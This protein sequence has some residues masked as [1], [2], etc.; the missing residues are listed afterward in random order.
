[1]NYDVIINGLDVH[2][3]YSDESINN[4]F[5][6]LLRKLYLLQKEKGRRILVMLAAP[7]GAG[8]ST[9]LSFLKYLSESTEGVSPI[10]TIGMDGFHRYQDYLLSHTTLRDGKAIQMVKIKG[11]PITFD[12]DL[13]QER[14][15]QVA[16]GKECGWPEYDRLKHN[17]IDN[18]MAVTGNIVLLEGNYLLLNED[19]WETLKEYADLTIK[20]DADIDMLRDRLINRKIKT[21]VDKES[22]IQ[23]VESS[24]LYNAKLCLDLS[25]DADIELKLGQD[26][27]YMLVSGL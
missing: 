13:L 4:I 9:L 2:A 12:I 17:P 20:I 5:I 7:P 24:D 25:S 6:P 26:N 18:A 14:I 22:A 1:M 15:K 3:Y 16:A 10:T 19:G 11:A 23:F 21:G 8:K 27:Q